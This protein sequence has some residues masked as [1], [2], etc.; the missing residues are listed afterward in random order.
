MMRTNGWCVSPER[1]A[2][3]ARPRVTCFPRR[4]RAVFGPLVR[5]NLHVRDGSGAKVPVPEAEGPCGVRK[6]REKNDSISFFSR[7]DSCY[8]QI[9]GGTVVVPLAV[10][11]TGDARWLRVNISCP[12]IKR[13]SEKPHLVPK[14]LP[15]KCDTHR[16]LRV[17]CGPRGVSSDAC[18][19]LG[20]CFDA[21][22][23]TCY[24]RL[25]ACSL[26]GHFVFS[27]RATDTDPPLHPGRLVVK[28]QPHCSPVITTTHTAV[29]KIGIMDCGAKMKV[30]GDVLS[31]EV[32]VEER[33]TENGT[34]HSP[35]SLQVQC[36]FAASDLRSLA[37]TDPPPV[38]ALG[39]IRVQMR[40][41]TDAS[42]TSF[43]PESEHPLTFPLREA[44]Y[45]EVS[46]GQP[47]PDP[48]LSL[49][50]RDCFAFPASRHSVW[51]LLYDGCPNPLDNMRSSIPV[52]NQGKTTSH[53]QVRRFDVKT[54]AFLD[55]HTGH[56]SVEEMYFYCWVEICTEDVECA[57]R[58]S[59]I[60]SEAERRRRDAP[61]Q[62]SQVQLISVLLLAQNSSEQ[63]ENP[64]VKQNTMFQVTLYMLSAVGAALLMIL[65]VIVSSS[66]RRT[67]HSLSQPNTHSCLLLR[68][69]GTL[70][71]RLKRVGSRS[72]NGPQSCSVYGPSVCGHALALSNLYPN[73][74][75]NNTG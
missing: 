28:D 47:S 11:L 43:Y 18:Y 74:G 30:D 26:D 58:C 33:Q 57:Q 61:S 44:V 7:Y 19:E 23:S 5:S 45:V 72:S 73:Y 31:Y 32:E 14:A 25:N 27:V 4:I 38:I 50:V 40:I 41:A 49:R 66:I 6:G 69:L 29:F 37:A 62:S 1:R 12:L 67:L 17:D 60:S 71:P 34:K 8:S 35:F 21:Y 59:I 63:Q 53:S 75:L 20:C 64:C 42:F 46:I 70:Q 68:K 65:L 16:A 51:T 56:P 10:Q 2:H 55:P 22:N 54:F 52:D 3:E 39:T 13:S 24:Y 36:E 15:G 9:K 48:T